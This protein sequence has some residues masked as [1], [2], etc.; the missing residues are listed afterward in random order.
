MGKAQRLKGANG[1]REFFKWLSSWAG[2]PVKRK[3]GQ[4]R[5]GGRD[6][7]LGLLV[8]EVKR[9]ARIS[10]LRWLEQAEASVAHAHDIPIVAMR[11]DNGRWMVVLNAEDF[12]S[13]VDRKRILDA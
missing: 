1:E 6:G 5:E 11:E 8:I 10:V 12:F 9:R 7:D 2:Y 13:L 4:A 3:L